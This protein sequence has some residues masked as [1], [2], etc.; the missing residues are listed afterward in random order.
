MISRRVGQTHVRLLRTHVSANRI[1]LSVLAAVLATVGI[2]SVSARFDISSTSVTT[3]SA[4]SF[5]GVAV[6]PDSMVAAFGQQLATSTLPVVASDTDPSTPG[7]QLPTQLGGS[8]VEVN[9]RRA[10]LFFVSDKQINYAVPGATETGAANVV[11]RSE[12][13]TTSTGTVQVAPVVPSVFTANADGKGVPAATLVRVKSDGLQSYER[14]SERNSTDNRFIT[15]PIDLGPEGERVFLILYVTGVRRANPANV[16]LLIGGEE[17]EP[18]YAG[19]APDFFGLDQINVEIPRSLLGRGIVKVSVAVNGATASNLVDIEIGGTS[20]GAPVQVMSF[21]SASALAGQEL[22][23]NGSGFSPNEADNLVRIAGLNVDEIMTASP[24]QLKVMVPFGVETGTVSVR[25]AHGEGIS[26]NILPVRTSISGHVENTSR[27]PLVGVQVRLLPYELNKSAIT[28]EEGSFVLPDVPV[29]LQNIEV[30]GGTVGTNPPYPKPTLKIPVHD[31]RDNQLTRAVALQQSTGSGGSVGGGSG[32]M[33]QRGAGTSEAEVSEGPITI[34]TGEYK[35][36]IENGTKA[37]FPSGATFGSIVLTPLKEAR[38]PVD[39]PLGYFSSAIVQITPFNVKLDPGAKLVLP[40]TDGFP[41]GAPALLFRYDPEQGKFVEDKAKVNVTSNGKFI[42]T[43]PGA[44]KS[45][46]YYFAAVRRNTTTLSGR[47]VEQR[48]GAPVIRAS[49]NF[50]GQES[51]TDGNG[52]YILRQVPVKEG[53]KASVEAS[54]LRSSGR[55]DRATSAA[56]PVVLGGTTKITPIFMP[57]FENR[58][59][60]IL[61]QQKIEIDEGKRVDIPVVVSDPDPKQTITV[62]IT[63]PSFVSLV[64][65]L[66]PNSASTFA[67]RLSPGFTQAGSYKITFTATDNLG[68][69]AIDDIEL[70]VNNVNRPPL[71]KELAITLDEDATAN[72]KLD[73]SDPDNDP[74]KYAVVTQPA[75]GT[76]TGTVPNLVYKPNANFNGV[77]RFSYKV[78][79]GQIDGN[80]AL[81]VITVRP[82]NDQ[83]VLSVPGAQMVD[84]GKTLSFSVSASDVDGAEGLTLT[85]TN[86]PTGATFMQAAT[87]NT[88]QF[89]WKPTFQQAGTYTVTFKVTD[90]G[91]PPLSDTKPVTITVK[92]VPASSTP[93]SDEGDLLGSSMATGDLNADGISDIAVGA[94]GAN[95]AGKVYVF[96]GKDELK[97]LVDL[98]Q[99]KADLEIIGQSGGDQFGSSLV[100]ADVNGDGRNDLLVGAPLSTVG[101]KLQV[102]RVYG[103]YGPLTE[104]AGTIDKVVSLSINGTA[105]GDNFGSSLTAG[106]LHTRNG[107]AADLFVGAPGVDLG[108]GPTALTDAGAV[109]GF[110]GGPAL[111]KHVEATSADFIATGGAANGKVGATLAAGNFNGDDFADLAVGAPQAKGNGAVYLVLG[112]AGLGGVNDLSEVAAMSLAGADEGDQFGAS[113]EMNDFNGDGRA[114]LI[115]GAPGGDGP[116]N[117]RQNAGEVAV[118]YGNAASQ[119]RSA[120]LLVYGVGAAGDEHPDALGQSLAIGDFTGDGVADIAMGAPGADAVDSKRLPSGAVY[121]LFGARAALTGAF[122]L[123]TRSADLSVYG[124]DAGDNLG[125]GAIAIGDLNASEVGD[126]ILGIP[127]AWSVNNQRQE[128]GEVRVLYGVKR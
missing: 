115:V 107:P 19:P 96:F 114:D 102:G 27:Q 94:P 93:Q 10:G 39:L 125:A 80:T 128:A 16:R 43:E 79:D 64:P 92:D 33:A 9:G 46:S 56:L 95:G 112:A 71:A 47:V 74:I 51:Y 122:D 105:R 23:I 31:R 101:D 76:L 86:L 41:A 78:N 13:G 75:S 25:T 21:G 37:N 104:F 67:L 4:A 98:E 26:T 62:R 88:G 83:P 116:D 36:E 40:N 11:I 81:A 113:L 5:E 20:G 50:R 34:Q 7:I 124:N 77:D 28:N 103:V 24:T 17:I 109:Y 118:F 66:S 120:D 2:G 3:V 18:I 63:A 85:A 123:A 73:G 6:A 65:T 14:L 15:K 30:D 38:T 127:R 99:Q 97:G 110:F 45:T 58:P 52:S 72:I 82:V 12:N 84:E 68:A 70:I 35:L 48:G 87:G 69:S 57:G 106:F 44:I 89:Q 22:I 100:I 1:L 91:N 111:G 49:V 32:L 119:S 117:S 60:T 59:P 42:E 29:G 108:A 121:L 61:V 55:V 53:E 54:I 90:N 8:T 126:L